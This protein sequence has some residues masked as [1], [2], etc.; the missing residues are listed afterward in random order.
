M[1]KNPPGFCL[2]SGLL[3]APILLHGRVPPGASPVAF[4]DCCQPA[5]AKNAKEEETKSSAIF[6]EQL[7]TSY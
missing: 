1:Y 5:A 3:S 4:A 7:N 2:P 6:A